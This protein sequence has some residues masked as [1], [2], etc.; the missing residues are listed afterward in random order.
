METAWAGRNYGLILTDI[1]TNEDNFHYI[2]SCVADVVT[3]H[4]LESDLNVTVYPKFGLPRWVPTAD[5]IAGSKKFKEKMA[6]MGI[7]VNEAIMGAAREELGDSIPGDLFFDAE[8]KV[9]KKPL[10]QL[11]SLFTSVIN[12]RLKTWLERGVK[13]LMVNNGE[14]LGGVINPEMIGAFVQGGYD[15]LCVLVD[16]S[17]G[18]GGPVFLDGVP[19]LMEKDALPQEIKEG[20]SLKNTNLMLFRIDQLPAMLCGMSV[21]DFLAASTLE[22]LAALDSHT[23]SRL[24]P[25][26]E[27]K[28]VPVRIIGNSVITHNAGQ[29]A[30]V[31]GHITHTVKPVFGRLPA[32]MCFY[33][34]KD[35]ADLPRVQQGVGLLYKGKI[36]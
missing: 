3:N 15:Y 28:P 25:L 36:V 35:F 24:V 19:R 29:A 9:S 20:M 14:D 22:I 1:C 11:M 7:S 6:R 21:R 13:V 17:A 12:G 27:I 4:K 31:M 18:G 8:G 23:L 10:G 34:L 16:A 5:Q 2:D 26:P 33:E 30:F 32:E